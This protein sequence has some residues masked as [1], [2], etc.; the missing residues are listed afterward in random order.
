MNTNNITIEDVAQAAYL[1]KNGYLPIEVIPTNSQHSNFLFQN[2]KE[3]TDL[4]ISWKYSEERSYYIH[5]REI[6]T[7][8][9]R[10]QKD[11]FGGR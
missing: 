7:T 10:L 9:F 8:A 1:I 5:Y 3:V 11:K 4:I 2:I 6:I